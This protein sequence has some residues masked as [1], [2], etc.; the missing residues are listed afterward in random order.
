MTGF[1]QRE[2][3]TSTGDVSLSHRI[4]TFFEDATGRQAT[5]LPPLYDAV[6]V[7]ALEDLVA[8]GGADL[9]VQ[10]RYCDTVVR[11]YGDGSIEF[12]GDDVSGAVPT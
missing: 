3:P 4:V 8:H 2:K 12:E 7:D 11:V 1:V 10:F 9:Q 5:E 6:D